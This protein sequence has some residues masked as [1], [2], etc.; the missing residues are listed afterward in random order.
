MLLANAAAFAYDPFDDEPSIVREDRIWTYSFETDWYG[1]VTERLVNCKFDGTESIGGHLYYKL[2]YWFADEEN[3]SPETVAYMREKN[4]S[5][6]ILLQ[7]DKMFTSVNLSNELNVPGN[8]EAILYDLRS[9]AGSIENT[10]ADCGQ[11]E[12]STDYYA[13]RFK[14]D[15]SMYPS[16]CYKYDLTLKERNYVVY[17]K[18]EANCRWFKDEGI[19]SSDKLS[20]GRE[21]VYAEGIGNIG[22]GLLHY[23]SAAGWSTSMIFTNCHFVRQTD[24]YGKVLFDVSWIDEQNG[25][26]PSS[27]ERPKDGKSY[28][29]TGKQVT[30][31][32]SGT[33]YI[34][35]GEKRIA[36]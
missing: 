21:V 22:R 24:L 1:E 13:L 15:F 23:T 11:F 10:I 8:T 2:N 16:K 17:M 4:G 26:T 30:D 14:P 12:E 33:I 3:P 27:Q 9:E 28:D 35:N 31:P 36:R 19:T 25:I 5:V 29:L 20:H 7:Q 32:E 6:Y 34:Q 18:P